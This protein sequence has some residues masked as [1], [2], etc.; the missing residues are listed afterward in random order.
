MLW[1]TGVSTWEP[2]DTFFQ[3]AP[4]DIANYAQK[5]NLFGNPHWKHVQDYVLNAPKPTTIVDFDNK[6]ELI[7]GITL[8]HDNTIIDPM[9]QTTA[10][11]KA[12]NNTKRFQRLVGVNGETCY[13][14]I[15]DHKSGA[16]HVS[17][18]RDKSPPLD[19]FKEWLATH[20]SSV[21][22][23]HVRLDGGGELGNCAAVNDLFCQVG[24]EIEVTAPNS[25]SEIGQA[26]CPH[27][28][29][30]NGVC[31]M[32][33]SAGLKP[34]YWL[35]ALCHFVLI[36]NCL[37]H[38]NCTELAL[39]LCTGCCPNLSLTCVSPLHLCPSY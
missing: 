3:D 1:S 28:T 14:L 9:D 4:Q 22:N 2:L 24:Y 38:G 12:A 21:S 26:E 36:S 16:W 17:I 7:D 13:V 19:F 39:E 18:Q 20:G 29:I 5:H 35:C 27:C 32:L 15:T 33:F 8:D 11:A 37:P 6:T 10:V 31:T 34:K 23:R 30:A 25:S